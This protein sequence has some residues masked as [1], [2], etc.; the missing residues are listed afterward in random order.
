LYAVLTQRI[1]YTVYW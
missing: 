1:R